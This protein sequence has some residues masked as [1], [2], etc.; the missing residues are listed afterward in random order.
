MQEFFWR[1]KNLAVLAFVQDSPAVTL[2]KE[3]HSHKGSHVQTLQ[4]ATG[5]QYS[6]VNSLGQ[7]QGQHL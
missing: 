6:Y 7:Q 3:S 1:G 5:A 4:I 2:Q